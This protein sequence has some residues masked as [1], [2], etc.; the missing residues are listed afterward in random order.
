MVNT[1]FYA[2]YSIRIRTATLNEKFK[3]IKKNYNPEK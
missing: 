3:L 1:P 2:G